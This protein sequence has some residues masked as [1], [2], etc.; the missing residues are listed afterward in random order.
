MRDCISR[1]HCVECTC[2]S[3]E[4]GGGYS[5]G[6]HMAKLNWVPTEWAEAREL[7]AKTFERIDDER[8]VAEERG[9]K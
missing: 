6:I 3:V 8:K 5:R 9:K 4:A 7:A 1:L 2:V